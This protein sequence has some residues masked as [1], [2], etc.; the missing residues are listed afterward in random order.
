M[1]LAAAQ[2]QPH[3]QD[4]FSN[5]EEHLHLIKIA[6]K[7]KADLIIFP[8]MSITGYERELAASQAFIEND[9]RLEPL[10]KLSNEHEITIVVGAP[11]RVGEEL[12]IGSFILQPNQK[13]TN[14]LKQ[15]LHDGEEKFFS[16]TFDANPIID[17]K[18]KRAALAICAD[19]DHHSHAA[20]AHKNGAD[21]YL[22]SIFFTPNGIHEAHETLS[23]Y[24]KQY[25]MEI[26][27]A[28]YGGESWGMAAGGRSGF[29]DK[30]GELITK[31]F[32]QGSG[33]VI[34]EE[35]NGK[36]KGRTITDN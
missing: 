11:I 21:I 36:W 16:S 23:S 8:E 32:D 6:V 5:F 3:R 28:N 26:L 29:W 30:K 31:L 34:V 22:A 19:I 4:L 14:Y 17:I 9:P 10:K 35:E 12:Y 1:I 33:L 20:N 24:A 27:M 7:E 25:Q 15:F 2:T 13:E 18:G